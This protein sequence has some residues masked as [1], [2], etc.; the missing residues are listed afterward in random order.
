MAISSRGFTVFFLSVVATILAVL[1]YLGYFVSAIT[2][3]VSADSSVVTFSISRGEGAHAISQRLSEAGFIA[4]TWNFEAY[5]WLKRWGSRLQAGEYQIPRNVTIQEVARILALGKEG[6]VER[7][8]T[9]IEGW[10]IEDIIDYL[11]HEGVISHSDFREALSRL[12]DKQVVSALADKP[13]GAS[14]E[15]YLFPDTYRILRGSSADEVVLKML[16]N[17]DRKLTPELRAAIAARHQ[18]IF[19][20]LTLASILEREVKHPQDLSLV[21]DVF[22]KRLAAG[23]PLES[24]ATLN[25]ILP[26]AE[27]KPALTSKALQN[28]AP[29]NSY[30]CPGLP[31][32]PISNPGLK[33]IEAAIRPTPN[34]Y[35]YFLSAST[36]ETIFSKTHA[37]H[38][39]NKQRYLT[40]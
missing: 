2:T 19:S 33:A 6:A 16:T 21:A 15:G 39:R 4:S 10:T 3:P 28:A 17:F 37:E 34:Q 18:T 40:D 22:Y 7:S 14:L 25:Y 38:V 32:G 1:L 26:V 9:I 31:P 23:K 5:I 13:V 35:W 27:R 8:I 30:R 36:G 20:T 24:D 12:A 11:D 29:Y